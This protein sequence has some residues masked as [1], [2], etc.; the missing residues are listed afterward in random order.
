M[1]SKSNSN[2]SPSVNAGFALNILI[3]HALGDVISPVIVGFLND[4]YGDKNKSFLVVG[5]MFLIAGT[6]WLIG[7]RYLQRDTNHVAERWN[8]RSIRAN[9]NNCK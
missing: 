3:I 2:A 5:F 8:R 9:I 6:L 7:A 1:F 4:W